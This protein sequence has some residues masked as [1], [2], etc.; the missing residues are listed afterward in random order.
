MKHV[1][2]F[3]VQDTTF[4]GKDNSGTALDVIVTVAQIVNSTFVSNRK[5]SYRRCVMSSEQ[6]CGDVF[7]NR[8]I[9]GAI[10]A[11]NSTIDISQSKF[12]YNAADFGGAIFAEQHSII[13]MSSGNTFIYNNATQDGGVLCS[14]SSTITIEASEFC[15]NNATWGGVLDFSSSTITIKSSKF[16][17]NSA[18]W[19]GVLSSASSTIMI[20]ASK[21]H[22]HTATRMGGVLVCS[23][24]AV[25]IEE[26]VFHNNSATWRG[27]VLDFFGSIIT[28]GG[29]NFTKNGSPIGAII[30]ATDNSK[31]Q[32]HNYLRIA[33]NS[34]DRYICCD[35][36]I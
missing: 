36:L 13:N 10:I 29:A 26:S 19:G 23:S 33:N 22:N 12:E 31:I 24:C 14:Y 25:T 5:G 21:F 34:A 30:F 18:G 28:V 2:E 11:T 7:S 17:D 6:R 35:I 15:S 8:F 4:K 20:E 3:V 27:G 1:K 32:Y 16:H 9:G